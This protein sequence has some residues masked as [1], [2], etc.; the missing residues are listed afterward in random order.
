M[1]KRQRAI[2]IV[3]Y[4]GLGVVL[5]AILTTI[6]PQLL[7]DALASKVGYNSEGY[8]LALLLGLWIQFTR[9][10]LSGT[11]R[12]WQAT[13]L[14]AAGCLVV[15]I[16]L[17][18]SDLPS[19]FKTLNETFIALSLILVYV[20]ARRRQPQWLAVTMSL[21]VLAIIVFFSTTDL[22]TDLAETL[23]MLLLVP[24]AFDVVD[25]G[26]LS[27]E[28]VT[29][30]RLRFAWYAVLV[31]VP[32]TF[33]LLGHSGNL[34][35]LAYDITR[36]DIRMHEAFVGVLLVELY[37]TLGLGRTGKRELASRERSNTV[38]A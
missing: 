1:S 24:L 37:F 18:N 3:F 34:T 10:R 23:G 5:A 15:G 17:F 11:S 26:I 36:Y 28:A 33:S 8:L 7:P 25:R 27:P 6:L 35:G 21:V 19:R 12:E 9:P 4:A 16:F 29:S 2:S 22:V 30:P 20:Q 38:A 32:T 14:A 31:M 13:A